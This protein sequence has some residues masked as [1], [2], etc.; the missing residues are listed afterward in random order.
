MSLPAASAGLTPGRESRHDLPVP[1]NRED[2]DIFPQRM[3]PILPWPTMKRSI[4]PP[5]SKE[6]LIWRPT[7]GLLHQVLPESKSPYLWERRRWCGTWRTR[8]PTWRSKYRTC[9]SNWIAKTEGADKFTQL[10]HRQLPERDM[11]SR[12]RGPPF[13]LLC[14]ERPRGS[15][16]HQFANARRNRAN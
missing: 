4:R 5:R 14:R 15:R 16:L 3:M 2:T 12:V 7:P 13:L 6:Q 9:T 8:S 11:Q 1:A 10:T